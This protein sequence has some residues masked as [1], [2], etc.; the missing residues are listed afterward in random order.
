MLAEVQFAVYILASR[1]IGSLYI[2]VISDLCCRIARLME[3][4]VPGF[5]KHYD[6]QIIPCSSILMQWQLQ[7]DVRNR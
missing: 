3:G 7:L 2:G 6:V 4:I 1:R 5:M